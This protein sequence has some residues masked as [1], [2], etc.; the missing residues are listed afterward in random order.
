MKRIL[1]LALVLAFLVSSL[2]SSGCSSKKEEGSPAGSQQT[3]GTSTGSEE[4]LA[5]IFAKSKNVEGISYDYTITAQGQTISGKMW[6][7]GEKVKT[8]TAM[9]GKKIISIIDS[10]ALLSYFP[11]ENRAMKMTLGQQSNEPSNNALEYGEDINTAPDKYKVL[12][13]TVY[14]G[15]MCRVVAVTGADGKEV[16]KMWVRE[17]YGFPVRVET[18][19]ANGGKTIIEYKNINIGKQPAEIF[20]LPAGVQVTDTGDMLKGLTNMPAAGQ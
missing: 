4:S 12:E 20:Q 6:I 10:N 1:S 14:D 17:D 19:E 18:V 16:M 3:T 8:E 15:V 7:S 9:E 13:R 2:F 5:S 11:D